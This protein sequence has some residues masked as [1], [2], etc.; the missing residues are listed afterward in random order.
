VPVLA[1]GEK[2]TANAVKVMKYYGIEKIK[3]LTE[4]F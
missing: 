3:V 2:I 4:L 1:S